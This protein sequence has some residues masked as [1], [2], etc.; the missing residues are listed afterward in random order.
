MTEEAKF[1]FRTDD[2]PSMSVAQAWDVL[3]DAVLTFRQPGHIQHEIFHSKFG[4]QLETAR[5]TM[6]HAII[7]ESV[8]CGGHSEKLLK[9]V[10]AGIS[11]THKLYMNYV[12]QVLDGVSEAI[13]TIPFNELI[14]PNDLRMG[15]RD[16]LNEKEQALFDKIKG[17]QPGAGAFIAKPHKLIQGLFDVALD[18]L[19]SQERLLETQTEIAMGFPKEHRGNVPALFAAQL[20]GCI[21]RGITERAFDKEMCANHAMAVMQSYEMMARSASLP[22]IADF[23][24]NGLEVF[25]MLGSSAAGFME[26]RLQAIKEEDTPGVADPSKVEDF[27]KDEEARRA[28]PTEAPLEAEPHPDA[29]PNSTYFTG[30]RTKH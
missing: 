26:Q 16:P 4:D 7:D 23:K 10:S 17:E 3:E 30:T 21:N 25:Q 20:V 28:A 1:G 12:V 15:G 5:K 11:V 2:S 13:Q 24:A 27:I 8:P 22:F 19:G 9:A 29:K 6:M 14:N 18:L